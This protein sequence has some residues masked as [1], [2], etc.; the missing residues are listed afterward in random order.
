[1][2]DVQWL[3][4]AAN[5]LEVQTPSQVEMVKRRAKLKARIKACHK[6]PLRQEGDTPVPV[7]GPTEASFVAVGEAPGQMEMKE[8]A[9]FV[10]KSGQLLRAMFSAAGL[11]PDDVAYMNTVCCWPRTRQGTHPPDFKSQLACRGNFVDQLA[12]AHTKYVLLVGATALHAFREDLQLVR[13]GGHVMI[14]GDGLV[15]MAIPHPAGLLQRK[16]KDHDKKVIVGQLQGWAKIVR[17]D[18]VGH[19]IMSRCAV[20]G[21]TADE[22][23]EDAIGYCEAHWEAGKQKRNKARVK[24]RGSG[25]YGQEALPIA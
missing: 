25:G 21:E 8:G 22:W 2:K 24:W 3:V 12:S 13:V 7:V 4:D 11:E 6:C 5:L 9:P 19:W 10:G 1:M 17:G 20:C 18:D 23:D 16:G 15:L 14:G